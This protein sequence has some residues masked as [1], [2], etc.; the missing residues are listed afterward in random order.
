MGDLG[1]IVIH[2]KRGAD[3]D[4]HTKKLTIQNVRLLEDEMYPD[5]TYSLAQALDREWLLKQ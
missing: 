4:D 2:F 3:S 1:A 5:V